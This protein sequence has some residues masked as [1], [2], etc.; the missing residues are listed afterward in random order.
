[1]P[2]CAGWLRS[3]PPPDRRCIWAGTFPSTH[4]AAVAYHSLACGVCQYLASICMLQAA[5][6]TRAVGHT[7]HA[8]AGPLGLQLPKH[9]NQHKPA[10]HLPQQL[11]PLQLPK[12]QTSWAL[13]M[14]AAA[15]Q[16]HLQPATAAQQPP[17]IRADAQQLLRHLLLQLP[18]SLRISSASMGLPAGL[19]HHLQQRNTA[20]QQLPASRVKAEQLL[21]QLLPQLPISQQISWASASLQAAPHRHCGQQQHHVL[22]RHGQQVLW[23]LLQPQRWISW[24][25]TPLLRYACQYCLL[26]KVQYQGAQ[27]SHLSQG[28]MA[29][30]PCA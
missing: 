12:Q 19:R 7:V 4:P 28:T 5:Y 11:P 10:R 18:I 20:L 2:S 22:L 24:A 29:S 1:M 9:R 16:P 27:H 17:I 26:S 15:R 3:S 13:M 8:Y 21:R 23:Q 30:H 14:A 25:S 6:L